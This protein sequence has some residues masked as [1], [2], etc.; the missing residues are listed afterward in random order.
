MK[1]LILAVTALLC[2]ANLSAENYEITTKN[3][4]LLLS[5]QPGRRVEFI[6]Y[7]PRVNNIND[8]FNTSS[9]IY[10]NAYPC[11]GINC[12]CEHALAVTH[13]NGDVS[14]ELASILFFLLAFCKICYCFN[15]L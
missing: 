13:A 11:F 3:T 12:T 1:R 2:A 4:T 15:H 8:I 6:Y 9:Q 7:G 14:L 10:W 5:T